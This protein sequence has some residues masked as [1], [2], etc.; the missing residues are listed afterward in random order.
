MKLFEGGDQQGGSGS[1]RQ[2]P[3]KCPPA[4]QLP[5]GNATEQIQRNIDAAHAFFDKALT[6]D[7]EGA[8]L[9]LFGYFTRQF[10]PGGDWDYKK[11]FQAG[12]DDQRN[13]RIFGN[14][15][16][17]AVLESFNFSAYFTQVAAGAAQV[18]I[19]IGGG[20]AGE[21]IPLFLYPYGDQVVDARDIR[22]GFDYGA[23]RRKGCQ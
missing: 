7:P 18:G 16:F 4:P 2:L 1:S 5:G 23:A 8:F 9:A 17:G 3:M 6:S 15:N 10:Q 13:A 22:R 21:G 14:F 12:T 19:W 11:D 20:A